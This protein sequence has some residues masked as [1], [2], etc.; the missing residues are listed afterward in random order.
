MQMKKQ[1]KVSAVMDYYSVLS[2]GNEHGDFR[3]STVRR[4][5]TLAKANAFFLGVML[6]Q[7]QLAE[8]AWDGGEHLIEHH[9]TGR[10]GF[11]SEVLAAHPQTVKRISTSGYDGTSYASV[12][13]T[14]KFPRWLRSAATK[15]LGE[16]QGDPRKIWS[17]TPVNVSLIYDRFLEFD[18]IG[19]ALAKM[20][21]FILVRNYRVA[22]GKK[23]Q[24]KMSVKPDVLV[25]R[26]LARMG[27]TETESLPHALSILSTL[28]MK[29]PADF[30]ASLWVLGREFCFKTNPNCGGCPVR[31]ECDHV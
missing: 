9:F 4:R 24:S 12:Y 19:D 18:G 16:Y 5:F 10:R 22:G 2:R 1:G 23:N 27:I 8:R 15:M 14:N 25:R 13:C 7:G 28:N 31:S 29:R 26:V 3:W 11:W 17:V 6:D 21:Q 20:A 30:D